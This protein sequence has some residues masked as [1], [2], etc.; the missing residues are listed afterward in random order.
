MTYFLRRSLLVS[1]LFGMTLFVSNPAFA[2]TAKAQSAAPATLSE[3]DLNRARNFALMG[4]EALDNG[5]FSSAVSLFTKALELLDVPTLRVG[6]GDALAH[7][8][9]YRAA[10]AD[11]EAAAAYELKSGDSSAIQESRAAAGVKIQELKPRLPRLR[12]DTSAPNVSVTVDDEAPQT[13]SRNGQLYLDPG[14]HSVTVELDGNVRTTEIEAAPGADVRVP[15]PEPTSAELA[16]APE[17]EPLTKPIPANGSLSDEM[18]AAGAITGVLAVGFAITG[19]LFLSNH[20]TYNDVNGDQ[21]STEARLDRLH[22]DLKTLQWVNLA[23]GAGALVGAGVTT[24]L[25]L[26]PTQSET[27]T[28]GL[29]HCPSFG[30][31]DGFVLGASGRF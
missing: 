5:N 17:T 20:A 24:Y 23:L 6:R 14:T 27:Q 15:A 7:L 11:Y 31:P 28:A 10:L 2:E 1:C 12:V 4:F 18:I 30:S 26:A 9:Q 29:G 8:N 21:S 16:P 3:E 19:I 22:A 13:L 25:W